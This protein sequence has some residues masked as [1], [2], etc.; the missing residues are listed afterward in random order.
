[1]SVSLYSPNQQTKQQLD[2]LDALLQRMLALPVNAADRESAPPVQPAVFSPFPA[3]LPLS[4]RAPTNDDPIVQAWRVQAPV[5]EP[6]G[7]ASTSPPPMASPVEV[8]LPAIPEPRFF[9]TPPMTS[10]SAPATATPFPFSVVYGPQAA[11]N[12]QSP[13]SMPAPAAGLPAP[14]WATQVASPEQ[15]PL[16]PGLWP[17]FALNKLFDLFTFLLGPLGTW[18]RQPSGRNTLG[19]LGVLMI[20]G[21]VGWG[22]ADWFGIDWT[23]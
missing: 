4:Q 12:M 14:P 18:L 1:M 9:T 10:P 19:W 21:A 7:F 16:S 8:P 15:P 11:S 5:A 6:N 13:L 22:V 23:R 2:E 20:L 17:L 3:T